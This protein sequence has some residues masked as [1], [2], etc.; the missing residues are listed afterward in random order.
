VD[1]LISLTIFMIAMADLSDNSDEFWVHYPN[2]YSTT[3]DS[4]CAQTSSKII[5]N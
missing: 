2:D 3:L 4:I 1:P 5:A